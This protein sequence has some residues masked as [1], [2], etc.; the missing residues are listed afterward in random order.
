MMIEEREYDND[1]DKE[2]SNNNETIAGGG[3][4]SSQINHTGAMRE[5]RRMQRLK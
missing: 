5:K 1:S 2:M 3:A 4:G